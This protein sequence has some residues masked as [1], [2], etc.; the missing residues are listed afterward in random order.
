MFVPE[1]LDH[2]IAARHAP[3]A[4]VEYAG[5]VWRRSRDN[6]RC[7]GD[8]A[9]SVLAHSVGFFVLL[10]VGAA[11]LTLLVGPGLGPRLLI[12]G[13]SCLMLATLWM[14]FHLGLLRDP[15][16]RSFRRLN[17]ANALTL[18]RLILIPG[19]YVFVVSGERVL[20]GI[21]FFASATTDVLDGMIARRFHQVTRMGIVLDPLVDM[22]HNG[23]TLFALAV[24]GLIPD[25]IFALVATRYGLLLLG[26]A[27]IYFKRGRLRIRPTVFGKLT[28]VLIT[29][30]VTAL[31][32]LR[33]LAPPDSALRLAQLLWIGLGFIFL[34][35]I[36]QGLVIG[37]HNLRYAHR[38]EPEAVAGDVPRR[39][40]MKP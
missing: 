1:Y 19:I 23:V 38:E 18:L 30:M 9:R 37:W 27:F 8:A 21:T 12:G 25:W 26:S 5:K 16:D 3:R 11:A 31:M 33:V 32:L 35:T 6:M 24:V 40:E 15:A 39:G 13:S 22:A 29:V 14:L 7:H 17:A 4:W 2:L 10:F 36:I 20:A 28:G 34:S